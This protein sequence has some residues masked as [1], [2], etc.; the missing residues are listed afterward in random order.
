MKL[1]WEEMFR[2]LEAYKSEFGH[3]LVQRKEGSLGIWVNRQ[4]ALYRQKELDEH[5]VKELN[6]IGF[7][8]QVRQPRKYKTISSCKLPTKN[9]IK[10]DMMVE[11]LKA[12]KQVNGHCCVPQR[13]AEDPAL[14]RWVKTKRNHKKRGLLSEQK[15]SRLDEIGFEWGIELP[16]YM[17]GNTAQQKG[18]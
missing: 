6:S 12:F 5:K 2:K 1:S 18:I 9:D 16:P 10:F 8:W 14:G 17:K 15:V 13:Y 4:R 3:C 11:K 7:V